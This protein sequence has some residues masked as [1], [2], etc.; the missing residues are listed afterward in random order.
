RVK[1]ASEKG[2]KKRKANLNDKGGKCPRGSGASPFERMEAEIGTM[3]ELLGGLPRPFLNGA[4]SSA[5]VVDPKGLQGVVSSLAQAHVELREDLEKEK[6]NGIPGI[7]YL[8]AFG[9]G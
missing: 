6:K 3:R 9:R 5:S 7:N 8:S 4:S 2:K 1:G